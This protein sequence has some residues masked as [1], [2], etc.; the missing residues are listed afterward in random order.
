[1]NIYLLIHRLKEAVKSDQQLSVVI[2]RERIFVMEGIM[3]ASS[4]SCIG[5]VV[6]LILSINVME[7]QNKGKVTMSDIFL[8][9]L[10]KLR[11]RSFLPFSLPQNHPKH[12]FFSL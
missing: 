10:C 5:F 7:F 2:R 11:L 4:A 8:S 12:T 3:A 9:L 6:C 1:M